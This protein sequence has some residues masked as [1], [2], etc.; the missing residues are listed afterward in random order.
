[1]LVADVT[2][3]YSASVLEPGTAIDLR[4]LERRADPLVRRAR[5][6]LAREGYEPARQAIERMV[7][8]RYVG[9]SYEITVPFARDYRARFDR[10]HGRLYG[11]SNPDRAT[12]VVAVRVRASGITSKPRLPFAK[13]RRSAPR[14]ESL[15]PAIFGG[16]AVKTAHYRW[17]ALTPGAAARGPAI[18]TG[19]EATVV[20]PPGFRFAVDGFGNV[21]AEG[22]RP[23]AI[24]HRP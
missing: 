3:D 17:P 23:K 24:G 11:Y 6:E 16:R 5:T 18:I 9:Q 8:V 4:A 7:D 19:A 14:P 15:R 2:R 1:M 21:I 10:E 12:E 22:R 20:V 13:P